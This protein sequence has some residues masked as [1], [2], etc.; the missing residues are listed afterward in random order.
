MAVTVLLAMM[1]MASTGIEAFLIAPPHA[2]LIQHD[3]TYTFRPVSSSYPSRCP[4]NLAMN[5]N[6]WK[7]E[8]VS[9]VEVTAGD[10][11]DASKFRVKF[12][13]AI[14][15]PAGSISIIAAIKR[16]S[17]ESDKKFSIPSV[18]DFSKALTNAKVNA[19]SVWVDEDMYG[20][21]LSDLKQA[22]VAQ[23]SFKGNFPG[24]CPVLAC[25]LFTKEE[26]IRKL[27][28]AGAAGVLLSV[29]NLND[30]LGAMVELARK[31]GLEPVVLCSSQEE[32]QAAEASG[33]SVLAVDSR[34]LG[35]EEAMKLA[36]HKGKAEVVIAMGGVKEFQD[37]WR[38]RD[39]GFGCVSV[40]DELLTASFG[41]EGEVRQVGGKEGLG[42]AV[43][44]HGSGLRMGE[45]RGDVIRENDV[46]AFVRG[47]TAKASTKFGPSSLNS[48]RE[49]GAKF[50]RHYV[51]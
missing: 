47:M 38:L 10:E 46:K 44:S 43:V 42:A 28:A 3:R 37:A 35:V 25:G 7:S 17:P 29:G 30:K 13:K 51:V 23:H 11:E 33:T 6:R 4:L 12:L 24:P 8:Q 21:T 39:A 9:K 50:K 19:I 41:L 14:K 31:E 40:G 20:C 1:A 15:K 22:V 45:V 32:M 48:F 36:E 27:S 2:G 26:D 49:A 18:M 5:V 34:L 16:R